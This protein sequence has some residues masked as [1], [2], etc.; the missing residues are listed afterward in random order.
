[1]TTKISVNNIDA[2]ITGLFGPKISSITI[3]N[4]S[5]TA[6]DDT[7]VSTSGGYIV[8][9][10]SNFASGC[11]VLI[12]SV[13]ATSVSFINSTTVRAQVP[14]QAAGSY[15]VYLT[16][17][18][19]GV[20]LRINGLNYSATPTWSTTSLLPSGQLN[21]AISIQLTATSNGNVS[22]SLQ[23]GS[24][25]P[26]GVT[27]SNVGLLS[28]TVTGI[29]SETTYNF[30]VV[31]TDTELQDTPQAFSITITANDQYFKNTTLLLSA[32]TPGT[33][34]VADASANAFNVSVFGDTKPNNFSPYLSGYYSNYFDGTGDYLSLP[35]NSAL[36]M[37]APAADFTFECWVYFNSLAAT[38]C[39][40]D[41]RATASPGSEGLLWVIQTSGR[42][43]LQDGNG[44]VQTTTNTGAVIVNRWMHLALVRT[45]SSI[46]LFVNGIQGNGA[47]TSV[48][49]YTQSTGTNYI[50][51]Y[52]NTGYM[53]GYI[54][55]FRIVKGTAVYTSNFT[56][57][58]APLTAIAN[59]SLLTC[60]SN[61]FLDS[62][63]NNFAIT[64]NGDTLVSGFVPYEP[65]VGTSTY[66]SGYFD[67]SGDQLSLSG[68]SAFSFPGDFTIE[69]W[70][71]PVSTTTSSLFVQ[72]V[73]GSVYFAL[74]YT[75][76]TSI[77]PYLNTGTPTITVTDVFPRLNQ[78]S[79]IAMVRSGSSV[80][81]Y[82]NG[83]ASSTTATNS[84]TLGSSTA[85][86]DIRGPANYLADFRIV[87]GTAVYT[88]NFTPPTAPLTAITNTSLLTLQTNQSHSNNM[89]VDRSTNNFF[90]TR[91]GNTTSGSFSPY[92]GSYSLYTNGT[93]SY[94]YYPYNSARAIGTGDFSIECWINVVRQPANFTRV[95]SHQGN[96]GNP[97]NIGVELAFDTV[98]AA[99]QTLIDGNSTTYYS[100]NISTS[101]SDWKNN[102]AHVVITR[103]SGTYRAF[104]NG[105]LKGSVANATTNIN[106]TAPTSFG[107]N[108]QLGG[109]LTEL[110]ISNFRLCVGSVP[111]SYQTSSTT[112]GTSVFSVPT[113][114]LTVTSQGA[115]G[116]QL[117]A[118][119]NNR[120]LDN[121]KNNFALTTVSNPSIQR[122]GPFSM[123][124][125]PAPTSY[126]V[127]FDGTG[128]YLRLSNT[129]LNNSA[130]TISF[131]FYPTTSSV[132][133]LFDSG[134]SQASTFRNY[135]ANTIQDQNGGSVAFT[136][137]TNQWNWMSIVGDGTNFTV[138]LNGSSAGTAAY[139]SLV[140]S[141]FTIG[142]INSGG[143]GAYTGYIS[144]FRIKNIASV[145][146]VPTA[147]LTAVA[148]TTLLTC[149][150]ATII[151]N[152]TN[153]YSIAVTG[154][155]APRQF[156]PLGFTNSAIG[157]YTTTSLGGS[158]YF[159]GSGDYLQLSA[160]SAFAPG[161][162]DYTI[163]A[164]VYLTATNANGSNI[165]SQTA[166]SHA[167]FTLVIPSSGDRVR[168]FLNASGYGVY[169]DSPSDF[170]LNSWNH[171]A[172]TRS[173]NTV[174]VFL[175][176]VAGTPATNSI[177][178]NNTTYN[179]RVGMESHNTLESVTGYVADVRFVKG[180]ALYT[181]NF[182][183]PAAPLDAVRNTAL[184]LRGTAAGIYD[185]AMTINLETV[186]DTRVNTS[187]V[188]F[189]GK[190]SIALDG[191]GDYI[192]VNPGINLEFGSGDFTIEFWW[193][194]TGSGRQALY[195]G[196]WGTDWSIGVDFSSVSPFTSNT[197]G[198]WA[199]SNG[200]SWNLIN[201]DGGGNGIGTIT[202][203]QNAWTHIAYAR[204]GNTWMLFINGVVDRNLTG[205][206]G[207]VVNRATSQKAIGAWFSD[208]AMAK[209]AG[210][211]SDFRI[212][213]YARYTT[214]FTPPTSQFIQF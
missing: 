148:N 172:A 171:C 103:Q 142:T 104:L 65:A 113:S 200:T 30:T 201:A 19:G 214:A 95:W 101:V 88:A 68:N 27:L 121:S 165:W 24:I 124:A 57:P 158:M 77:E 99:L 38:I 149:Q 44:I 78:W 76:G 52:S 40:A 147:P 1:M 106:G 7:A 35:A 102:W 154:D 131:W 51:Q 162:G 134:P 83:I 196:S 3:T 25:L 59:T 152:S 153:T 192:L 133:G 31:A 71:Y 174:R 8:I 5:Y 109:D 73:P 43:D 198:I 70:T 140:D 178:L 15:T 170:K 199:S 37:G 193:Y 206:S 180:Q 203:P 176:G 191:T 122:F 105:V 50:G 139:A 74:N 181:S 161:T 66:G 184:L 194:R 118:F 56:T 150:S 173:G 155:C 114:P 6:L 94:A 92:A 111:T 96:W 54:S 23:A 48:T 16:N 156:N 100:I 138:Y 127:Y 32:N 168:H 53:N 49:T 188:K 189:S 61:R 86:F 110:Y 20:A 146:A 179:P 177:N 17:P 117:L 72:T 60:Q 18:D 132:V 91:S 186:G 9:T 64:R 29:T 85:T 4:N 84:S 79:H 13:V 112:A 190:N 80:K 75:A 10:G 204:T 135:P 210:Y 67:G 163:E 63:A 41:F 28:G 81:I 120:F 125:Q 82:V 33:T 205:I 45:S 22:Y 116:V 169:Y 160:N 159:D 137:N 207:T 39:L 26:P 166:S 55:N 14:A 11:T 141:S 69:F 212:T 136:A 126:S 128:D 2:T 42:V 208:A 12:G 89:F 144:N 187:I 175:N 93:S 46:K 119:Q 185:S 197:I 123:Q 167:Y 143:D 115:S 211:I 34:F 21:S 145:D 157:A 107:T 47:Y 209:A 202:V 58:T 164:W 129:V 62:S 98:D 183:P 130:F 151:D 182:V 90:I 108:S 36:A 87:K 195:H 97:G 213:K